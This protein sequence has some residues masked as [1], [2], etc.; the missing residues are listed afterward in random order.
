VEQIKVGLPEESY[1][2][3][4][5]QGL[6]EPSSLVSLLRRVGQPTG[7]TCGIITNPVVGNLYAERVV[8]GL[9]SFGLEPRLIEIPEG[10]QFKTLDTVRSVYDQLVET[11]LDRRSTIFALGGG[12]VGDLAGF[13][14][15]TYLRGVPFIQIPT[16]LLAMVDA[17]IGGKVAVDHPR[18]KNLVGAFKQ[19]L[20]V[21]VDTQTLATLPNEEWRSGLAEVVKHALVG[22]PGLLEVLESADWKAELQKW[23]IRAL[24]VKVDIVV[25]D[26]FEQGERAKLNLGHTFGHALEQLSHYQMRHGDAVAIGLVCASRLSARLGKCTPDLPMRVEGVLRHLG[27]PTHIPG[28]FSAERIVEAMQTDKKRI[29]KRLRFVLP[30]ALGNVVIEDQGDER[31]VLAVLEQTIGS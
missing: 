26:P 25:R 5:G 3:F 27:L 28:E 21:I 16:T 29:G 9:R 11:H 23:I 14:A 18:G 17:S 7:E 12:V 6:I 22:D 15:A 8:R 24:A 4:V 2:V 10:E 30:R 20:A 1:T 13:A 19:P 31:D